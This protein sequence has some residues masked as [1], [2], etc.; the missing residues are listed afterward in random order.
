M[1]TQD[2]SPCS[3]R[4]S[5]ESS[6]TIQFKKH[7]ILLHSAFFI[8]QVSHPNVSTG[9]TIAL[10]RQNFD[11]KTMSLLSNMLSRLVLTFLPRNKHLLCSWLQSPSAVILEPPKNKGSNCFHCFPIYLPWSDGTGCHD[12]S[13]PNVRF[14]PTFSPFVRKHLTRG[15]LCAVLDLSG[16]LWPL[17]IPEYSGIKRRGT[18]FLGQ[19]NPG[20][21]HYS[22]KY[23]LPSYEKVIVCNSVF[24]RDRLKFCKSR[25]LIFTFAENNH[26]VR[27]YICPRRV[28]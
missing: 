18:P 27:Q 15:F 11:D 1:N 13:F 7:Q 24:N 9:K 25:I 6:P 23:P 17:L 22:D 28:D 5:Q 16:T 8:V 14:K 20:S 26:L 4:D 21:S 19:R 12:L 10:T 2:W 3:P